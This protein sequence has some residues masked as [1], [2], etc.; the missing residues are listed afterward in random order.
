M[1]RL[2][3]G[4]LATPALVLSLASASA[5]QVPGQGASPVVPPAFQAGKG[6]VIGIDEAHRNTHTSSTPSFRGLVELLQRDGYQVR[7]FTEPLDAQSLP[8]VN[9]LILSGPGGWL[10]GD[11]SLREQEVAELVQWVK[12]GGSLLL[13]LGHMPAPRHAERLITAL[14]ISRWH[15][16]YAMVEVQ[17]SLVGP[18]NFWRADFLPP[19]HPTLGP[20]GPRGGMGYQGADAVLAPHPITEGRA[21]AERVRRVATFVG[22]AFQLPSGAEGL[23][24]LP[25]R[26]MSLT[27]PET[28]GVLPTF[29]PLTPRTS[30]GGWLQGAVMKV[31]R[32]R[33]ALFGDTALFSGGP[34]A[35]NRSF[36]LNVMH[37]LSGLL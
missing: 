12:D 1:H 22:S 7:P 19:G 17:D 32:G 2:L 27:P 3:P 10:G 31:G 6:P 28:P 25:T 11:A 21:P 15:D 9:V 4:W 24:T 13:I 8:R 26:T 23:L 34:A 20:T 30:V 33:V 5:Q 16:G 37:W 18:I 14:E 29:T 36:V 35:D